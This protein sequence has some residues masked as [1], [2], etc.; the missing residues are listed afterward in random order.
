MS[1]DHPMYITYRFWELVIQFLLSGYFWFFAML[2]F[3]GWS[4]WFMNRFSDFQSIVD[5]C[6]KD[7]NKIE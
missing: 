5:H 6:S 1:P 2:V 7:K 3:F 4:T